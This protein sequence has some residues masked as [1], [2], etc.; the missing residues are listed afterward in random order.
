MGF[1]VKD[2]PA[3]ASGC[4]SRVLLASPLLQSFKIHFPSNRFPCELAD[5]APRSFA[6]RSNKK[7]S[8][9]PLVGHSIH[10][11]AILLS[12]PVKRAVMRTVVEEPFEVAKN[13]RTVRPSSHVPKIFEGR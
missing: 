12:K 5:G 11:W 9:T 3:R 1:S 6:I 2:G 10:E 7:F 4:C 8:K 13:D